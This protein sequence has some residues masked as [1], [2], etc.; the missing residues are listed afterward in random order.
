VPRRDCLNKWEN[1]E[2]A[3]H[4]TITKNGDTR[5]DYTAQLVL[6]D[7]WFARGRCL[8]AGGKADEGLKAFD[9]SLR[10]GGEN[11]ENL[12]NIGSACAEA[13]QL[14][15]ALKRYARALEL[16]PEYELSL[17]NL[18]KV[19]L[20][21]QR[22]DYALGLFDRVLKQ[23]PADYE[24]LFH[25]AQCLAQLGRPVEAFQRYQRLSQFYP[26]DPAAYREMGYLLQATGDLQGAQQFY[27][28]SLSL[29]RNQ[30]QLALQLSQLHSN[31][32][33]NPQ[34]PGLPQIPSLP[35]MPSLD[36]QSLMPPMPNPGPTMP[37]LPNL[38]SAAPPP[39]GP[40]APP[41]Q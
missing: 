21:Q 9:E 15:A 31:A 13:G 41:A 30:P 25:G 12:N 4:R 14:D 7:Y 37:Q 10:A 26:D 34:Q 28:Q 5:G 38:P 35:E 27:T 16:D 3:L 40:G 20:Q 18:G 1:A 6:A 33:S 19:Y 29:D 2:D 8:L 24:G 22:P 39:A 17:K 11:R 36:P 32:T 23:G